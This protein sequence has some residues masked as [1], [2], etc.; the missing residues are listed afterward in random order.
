ML[1]TTTT[2]QLTSPSLTIYKSIVLSTTTSPSLTFHH[3]LY[4]YHYHYSVF[5]TTTNTSTHLYHTLTH[6]SSSLPLPLLVPQPPKAAIPP[7]DWVQVAGEMIHSEALLCSGKNLSGVPKRHR[8]VERERESQRER[9]RD[10]G[11]GL[12]K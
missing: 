2:I 6:L 3:P 10:S 11:V 9:E 7:P 1:T 8:L 4:H 5:L 12:R